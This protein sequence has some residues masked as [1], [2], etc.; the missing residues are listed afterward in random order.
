MEQEI[1][2][3]SWNFINFEADKNVTYV[4]IFRQNKPN[5]SLG[6]CFSNMIVKY[7][8]NT[9]EIRISIQDRFCLETKGVSFFNVYFSLITLIMYTF[10]QG[11]TRVISIF[12][13]S[14]TSISYPSSHILRCEFF[15]LPKPGSIFAKSCSFIVEMLEKMQ[16]KKTGVKLFLS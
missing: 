4:T 14:F 9:G 13:R 2:K 3:F 8:F 16:C 12:Q 15:L 6:L 11:I 10:R 7:N 5:I 1:G